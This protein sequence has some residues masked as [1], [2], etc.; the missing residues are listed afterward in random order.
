MESLYSKTYLISLAKA[1]DLGGPGTRGR[2]LP[3]EFLFLQHGPDVVPRHLFFYF[4]GCFR[5]AKIFITQKS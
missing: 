2:C 4:F 1:R 5:P 3:Q